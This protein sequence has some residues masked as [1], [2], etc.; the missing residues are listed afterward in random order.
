[1]TNPNYQHFLLLPRGFLVLQRQIYHYVSQIKYFV[2]KCFEFDQVLNSVTWYKNT[3]YKTFEV[4]RC[5]KGIRMYIKNKTAML[6][7]MG[8]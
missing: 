1:M 2:C 5:D 3:V 8:V 7:A 6:C 4:H